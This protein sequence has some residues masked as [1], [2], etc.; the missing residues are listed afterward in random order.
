MSPIPI[1]RAEAASPGYGGLFERSGTHVEDDVT[2]L[3]HMHAVLPSGGGR[4]KCCREG[5]YGP[6]DHNLG[7][8]RRYSKKPFSQL[9][10]SLGFAST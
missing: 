4:C 5:L 2:A 9:A 6:I 7:H 1:P 8:Y 10:Q 3:K